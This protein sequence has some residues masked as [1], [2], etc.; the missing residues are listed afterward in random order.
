MKILYDN[1]IF[2]LQLAGGISKVWYNLI[3][4]IPKNF[5]IEYVEGLNQKNIFR[6]KLEIGNSSL[7]FDSGKNISLRQY[8]KVNN[9]GCDIYHSSY[10]RPLKGKQNS[11]VV[12]TV[13]DFMYEKYGKYLAKKNHLFLK[14]RCINQAD[15]II[16]V[17][18]CTKNDFLKYYPD[19]NIDIVHVV[20]NGVD[21]EFK[22]TLKSELLK[23]NDVT[24]ISNKYLLYVGNRGYCKNFDFVLNLMNSNT[25]R[26]LGYNLVCVGGGSVSKKEENFIETNGLMSKIHFINNVGSSQLNNLYNNAFCLLFPSL[27]EGFGIP[28]V[29]AM[30]V[31]CPVWSTNSSSVL[32]IIGKDYPIQFSP[33]NWEE[34]IVVFE[35]LLD[36]EFRDLSIEI[37]YKAATK[38][39]W[40][41]CAQDTFDIYKSLTE[42]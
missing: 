24:F 38:F 36:P 28:A 11:K 18:H 6:K 4:R 40:N 20:Y 17:S 15:A 41:K 8:K 16:C 35:K 27:Y 5:Q 19:I 12:V 14:N 21:D 32:E 7:I 9:T 33:T 37:G 22:P 25:L 31:G 29:E 1:F 26:T 39:S 13:H 10:F 23:I 42:Q 30:K 2:D 3:K 34:A